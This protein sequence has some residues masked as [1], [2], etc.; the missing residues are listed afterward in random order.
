MEEPPFM[1]VTPT[2]PCCVWGSPPQTIQSMLSGSE[3]STTPGLSTTRTF[4]NGSGGDTVKD[5][6][7]LTCPFTVT[8]IFPVVAPVGADATIDV[9]FQLVGAATSPLNVRV[10]E[11]CVEPKFAPVIV[12]KVPTGPDVGFR[13]EIV[14]G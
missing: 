2:P 10:L 1:R 12:T 9:P 6:V 4:S 14:G 7:L 8:T 13:L 3:R 11:P 5:I